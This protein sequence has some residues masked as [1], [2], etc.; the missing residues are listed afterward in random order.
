MIQTHIM[1]DRFFNEVVVRD[2]MNK[3]RALLR[4]I[5]KWEGV[6]VAEVDALAAS[7][8][9]AMSEEQR[10]WHGEHVNDRYYGIGETK[11]ALYRSFAVS[12]A[13][14]VENLMGLFCSE[15]AVALPDRPNWHHKRQGLERLIGGGLDINALPSFDSA[16]RARILAN[17]FKHSSGTVSQEYIDHIGPRALGEEVR[18]QDENWTAVI[19][20]IQ[21]ALL[22]V[23]QRLPS[24]G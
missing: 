10:H 6:A 20:G 17:C 12:A 2:E 8:L 14:A 9:S 23:A 21:A 15:H 5:P 16:N 3:L 7:D 1:D 19:D 24:R 18:Y 11:E 13:S 22:V 4:A